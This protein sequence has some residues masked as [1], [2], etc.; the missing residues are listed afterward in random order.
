MSLL[1]FLLFS[2]LSLALYF[3]IIII[4]QRKLKLILDSLKQYPSANAFFGT[5]GVQIF[6]I[7]EKLHRQFSGI[8]PL[9]ARDQ[10]LITDHEAI[11]HLLKDNN[12]FP[13]NSPPWGI[14]RTMLA[15]SCTK[16]NG[17]ALARQRAVL[18]KALS[19]QIINQDYLPV[20]KKHTHFFIQELIHSDNLSDID[21]QQAF[22]YLSGYIILEV[23]IG[24]QGLDLIDPWLDFWD[25]IRT[26]QENRMDDF[27][28]QTHQSFFEMKQSVE[29]IFQLR[30]TAMQQGERPESF[31]DHL[32]EVSGIIQDDSKKHPIT[33]SQQQENTQSS[34]N[35]TKKDESLSQEEIIDNI[36]SFL[37]AGFETVS[38]TLTLALYCLFS[39]TKLSNVHAHHHPSNRAQ[40]DY[41]QELI[42][43]INIDLQTLKTRDIQGLKKTN[44][45]ILETLRLYPPVLNMV[46]FTDN[47]SKK[48]TNLELESGCPIA[49][50]RRF[51]RRFI[52][53]PFHQADG[54]QPKTGIHRLD[55]FLAKG[56]RNF[57]CDITALQRDD[58]LWDKPHHFNPARWFV[59]GAKPL[60]AFG[61]GEKS[62]IGQ[63]LAMVETSYILAAFL[64]VFNV[65]IHND[66]D[67]KFC[68]TPTLRMRSGLKVELSL[69]PNHDQ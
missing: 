57:V 13:K 31:L 24:E 55:K 3:R 48:E 63:Q 35:Q 43:E 10:L 1:L 21:L 20:I 46:R 50:V 49:F 37:T 67:P 8:V 58:Q 64:Q 40:D 18:K 5:S 34:L 11:R 9:S 12:R 51:P 28:H 42:Q 66:F 23:L 60:L 39:R 17:A 26:P 56:Y 29:A 6:K 2:I 15:N 54:Q 53:K 22:S 41:Y 36:W 19:A 16:A 69:R 30:L 68:Q 59:T 7:R 27:F 61:L 4:D 52:P 33:Q 14:F 65:K 62:C 38:G 25:M 45:V 32:I 47:V 44:A